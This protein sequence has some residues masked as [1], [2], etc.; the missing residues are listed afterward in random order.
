L[1]IRK[2][3]SDDFSDILRVVKEAFDGEKGVDVSELVNDLLMDASANPMLSLLAFHEDEAVGHILFTKSQVS[4]S[5][6]PIQTAILAPLAVVPKFHSQG[7][8]GK[9]IK[10]GLNLL[11]ESGVQLVFVLGH[12]SYYPSHG[13]IP[14][15]PLGFEAPFQASGKAWMVQELSPGAIESAKGQVLCADAL[16]ELKHW[17]G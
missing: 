5:S 12:P 7:I 13:F 3:N 8:G 9:L 17:R 4:E 14:A 2:S 11:A 10:E 6:R 15:C 16:N 1:I